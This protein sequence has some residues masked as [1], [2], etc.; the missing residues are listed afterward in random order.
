MNKS[1][2]IRKLITDTGGNIALTFAIMLMPIM[3]SVGAA[4]DYTRAS[5]LHTKAAQATDAALLSA[6]ASVVGDVD[7]DDTTAVKQRLNREFEPFFLANL[8]SADSFQYNGFTINF[9]PVT[10]R[11]SVDVDI[12]YKTV[13]LGIAGIRHWEA[14]VFAAASMQIKAGGAI[15]M[16]LVLD[17]SGSMG[18]DDGYGT[19]KMKSLKIAVD[20]M[21]SSFEETDPEQKYIRMG[22][23]AYSSHMW[24]ALPISWDLGKT[25]DYVKS[26]FAKGGTNSSGSVRWA[27]EKLKDSRE[28]DE[29]RKRNGKV[30]SFIMV[31]MTDG[32]NN[33][34]SDDYF[35]VKYCNLAKD[36][37]IEI[38]TIAFRAP[39]KGQELLNKC[40]SDVA[41]SFEPKN[42]KQLIEAFSNIGKNVG[43]KLVLSQ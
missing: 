3:L 23:T 20:T 29:H 7:L 27:Y 40:A 11:V 8:Q 26:M 18:W 33:D 19:K 36:Y 9:N 24:T 6:V 17:R 10:N 22:A 31:F 25:N 1:T 16:A 42:T 39:K 12:D 28:I 14:D 41:H 15:S 21:I 35:T 37:G 30:P 34:S 32:N 43:E 5:N 13:I 2:A 38:Y 4:V